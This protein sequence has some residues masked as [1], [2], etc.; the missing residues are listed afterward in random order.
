[1][2][3]FPIVLSVLPLP[4][5]IYIRFGEPI[6]LDAPPEAAADQAMVDGLN[7]HVLATL[8]AL[9]DDTRRRR[10]G[11]YCSSYTASR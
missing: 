2:P 3:F 11:V 10:H 7:T 6:L 9:I 1:M 8:Q 5:R 4:A